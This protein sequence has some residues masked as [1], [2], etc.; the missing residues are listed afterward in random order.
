MPHIVIKLISG[1]SQEQ[2][3]KAAEQI[4]E[5]VEKTLGKPKKYTSVSVEEYSFGEW[6][7][8]YDEFVKDKPNVIRKP[9]YTNRRPLPKASVAPL[10]VAEKC[11][12]RTRGAHF[13]LLFVVITTK[14]GIGSNSYARLFTI[15]NTPSR[16]YMPPGL[17]KLNKK[18]FE[19]RV[20]RGV[21]MR[22]AAPP[23]KPRNPRRR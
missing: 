22:R 19:R 23:R 8:V 2:L 3:K 4:V 17:K 16:V 13:M 6:P 5:V 14:G 1:P 12:P 9:E 7:G 15:P 10:C 20:L 11:A 18:K 21:V